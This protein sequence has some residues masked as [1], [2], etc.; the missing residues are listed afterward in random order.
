MMSAPS[1]FQLNPAPED[2]HLP[3]SP[4][5]RLK[6][7]IYQDVNVFKNVDEHAVAV[8]LRLCFTTAKY[9]IMLT[10]LIA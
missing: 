7:D 9:F 8:S 5:K 10:V 1:S 6:P 2:L 3:P 4:L